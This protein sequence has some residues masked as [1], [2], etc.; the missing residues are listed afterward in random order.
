[1]RND[2]AIVKKGKPILLI[3]IAV[4]VLMGVLLVSC[5]KKP[6]QESTDA[7]AS[8]DLPKEA[9]ATDEQ[10]LRELL[11]AEGEMTICVAEDMEVDQQFIVKGT[12]TLTGDAVI[13]M[14][15]SAEWYQSLLVVSEGATL[16]MDGPVLDGNYIAD[17]IH[18]EE[19][20]NLVYLSGKI[21]RTDV[22][23]IQAMGNVSIQD[24]NIDK[25]EYIGIY[26]K[27]GSKVTIEGGS[28]TDT[29][30]HDIY[31]D[32]DATVDIIGNAR[33]KGCMGDSVINYGTLNVR[34]GTF[35]GATSYTFNNYGV[36]DIDYAGSETN[37]YVEC[38]DSRLG[39]VCTRTNAQTSIN[40]LH[41]SG[42]VRQAV[43]TVGGK[44]VITDSLFE[45]TGYHAIEIQAGEAEIADVTVN[46]A[47]DAG[48]EIYTKGVVSVK[49]FTVN[50]AAGIG[51]TCRGGK[52][53]GSNISIAN[54][55]KYGISCGSSTN[56]TT[57]GKATVSDIVIKDTGRS[58]AYAYGGAT[59]ELKNA[60]I[61]GSG[62]RGIYI[63][64]NSKCTLSGESIVT[65]C[66][67]RGVEVRGTF[68]M[69][70]GS[71]CGNY[72]SESGAG[73]Y[74]SPKGYF[75]MEGGSI[76]NNRSGL[77]GGGV[78]VTE[79]KVTVNAGNI[80]NNTAANNGGGLYAQKGAEVTL[81]T[82]SI[83][84][85]RSDMYGDGIYVV[86]EA[87]KITMSG[88]FYVGENDIKIDN[89]NIAM[90][91]TRNGLTKHTKSDPLRLTPNYSAP[92][93]TV[94]ATCK[95]VA[96]AKNVLERA[97][98]GDGS[99]IIVRDGK[100]L[101]VKYAT[102]DMD[103]TDAD[104][105]YVSNFQQLK[106]AVES[107]TSK[108][109]IILKA[110]IEFPERIR[111]PGGVTIRI[112]DDGTP[113]SLTR[114][115][116]F[117]G[118][119]FVTHYGTGLYLEG[120]QQGNLVLDGTCAETA[121][122]QPLVR[123][124]GSTVIRN[125]VLQN[126]G[127]ASADGDVRGA[128]LRQLY[129]DFEIYNSALTGGACNS[130]GAI[131]IDKGTGY[132]EGS[133][134][135]NNTSVIGGGAI[136]A[137]AN[138]ELEIVNSAF[139]QNYAGSSGGA[140][141][142]VGGA[143]VTI[144]DTSFKDN[145]AKSFGG[146]LN[147]QDEGTS[148]VITGTDA[149][150]AVFT[151][152]STET[153]GAICVHTNAQLTVSGYTFTENKATSG[154]AGA[155]AVNSG[156][157]AAFENSGFHKNEATGSGGVLATDG[158]KV[159]V[160]SCELGKEGAGNVAG[161]KG[162]AIL[163]T[164]EGEV[165]LKVA[166]D[167]TLNA[168]SNNSAIIGGA[169][170]VYNGTASVENYTLNDNSAQKSGG[171]VYVEAGANFSSN[172]C[173]FEE[174][175]A[176]KMG[177]AVYT[178]G[179]LVDTD[180]TYRANES[181]IGGALILDDD[182]KATVSGKNGQF[183]A[184]VASAPG[185]AVY[186]SRGAVAE[187][188]DYLF[189]ENVASS[190]GAVYVY[191]DGS[192]TTQ[193]TV[194]EGNIAKKTTAEGVEYGNGGA[195]Q[196]LGTYEDKS[197]SFTGN[198]GKNGGA[199]AVMS[200]GKAT[201]IATPEAAVFADNK[202]TVN[203]GAVFVNKEGLL[204]VT[205]YDFDANAAVLGGAVYITKESTATVK[206]VAMDANIANRG[207][208]IYC[209]APVTVT[210]SSFEENVA[211][212]EGGALYA[213][214]QSDVTVLNCAFA[215]N[216]GITG[217]GAIYVEA[218]AAV[219]NTGAIFVE[220]SATAEGN[221]GAVHVKGTYADA[222]SVYTGNT[223]KNGGAIAVLGGGSAT[224]IG[225]DAK[226]VFSGNSAAVKGSAVFI[227]SGRCT[228]SVEGY[229][230]T[231]NTGNGDVYVVTTGSG[232]LKNVT[233]NEG[234]A[235]SDG[236]LT[237]N[238]VTGATL[239]QGSNAAGTSIGKIY[240]AGFNAA[241]QLTVVPY[242]Y[243]GGHQVLWKA[244]GT[245]D[246]VFAE[247]CGAIQVAKDASGM[248]WSLEAD[249][250]LGGFAVARIGSETFYSLDAAVT[251]ANTNGSTGDGADMTIELLE[252]VALSARVTTSKNIAIVNASGKNVTISR[253]SNFVDDMFYVSAGKLTLGTNN[254][255]ETGKLIVDA[256]SAE[257]ISKRILDNRAGA[258]FLL[259]RNA[260]LENSNSNQWGA[261]FVN[262]GTAH[263]YGT[264]RNNVCTGAGGAVL[265]VAAADGLII[266]EGTYTGNRGTRATE[267]YGGFLRAEGSTVEIKG[268]TFADNSA[269]HRG[270]ALY[271]AGTTTAT[272]T[273]GTFTNNTSGD[274]SAIY[275][276]TDARASL[277]DLVL[278]D[279]QLQVGGSVSVNN[280]TGA[281]LVQG[282]K[283]KIYAVSITAANQLTVKPY[284][285]E[286]GHQVL[287]K[288]DGT[289]DAVLAAASAAVTVAKDGAGNLWSLNAEGKLGDIAIA[290]V[291]TKQ[292]S[293]LDAAIEYANANGGT[294]DAADMTITLLKSVALT[295]KLTV[296]KNVAIVNESGKDITISRDAAFTGAEMFQVTGKLTLGTNDTAHTGKLTVDAGTTARISKRAIANDAGAIFVLAKNAVLENAWNNQWGAALINKGTAHLYG[297]IRNNNCE[298]GAGGA[299]L[300]HG[301]SNTLIIYE[302]TYSGNVAT[303]AND[304][305][306]GFLRVEAGC[307]E[308][309]G[310]VF[311]NNSASHH[312]G[313]VYVKA[314]TSVSITGATF[315]NN[316][317]GNGNA[318]YIPAGVAASLKD[319]SLNGQQV[320][321]DGSVS[322]NNV[323]G[324]TLVQGE[325][326][327]IYAE[328]ITAANQLSVKPYKY[329]SGYV[330]LTKAQGVED[331]VFAQ[332]CAAISVSPDPAAWF[333]TAS[334][335][336]QGVAAW[337]GEQSFSNF[338]SALEYANSV[339]NATIV[340]TSDLSLTQKAVIS[341]NI[342]IT[343]NAGKEITV[344]R[345]F[346]NDDM[347]QVESGA[348]LTL[349]TADGGVLIVNGASNS[350]IAYRTVNNAG[351]FVLSAKA[352]IV[353]ANS[354]AN[355][356]ALLNSGTA[357]LSGNV[358]GNKVGNGTS[359]KGG[360]LYCEANSSTTIS[361]GTYSGNEAKQGGAIYVLGSLSANDAV[362]SENKSNG[363]EG[364]A[365]Y[366]DATKN[367][368]LTGCTFEDNYGSTAG[369][370]YVVAGG[371]V[372]CENGSFTGNTS[373][374]NGGA[375]H[376]KG[377]YIDTNSSYTNNSG[378]NGGAVAVL[379]GGSATFTGT[380]ANAIFNGNS[381]T[382]KGSAIFVNSGG[383]FAN[384]TGYTF[385]GNTTGDSA[386]YIV[387][388]GSGILKN[389]VFSGETAQKI[390]VAGTLEYWNIT[391]ASIEG[392]GTKTEK[393]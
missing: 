38:S 23:G 242:K 357:V 198:A 337:V 34:D 283:G 106:A 135:S 250:K 245:D 54:T 75:V 17:G 187:V 128:L 166:A 196:V 61:T 60:E 280:V 155:I 184:N 153:A 393:E 366:V 130:G 271:L 243:E 374:G 369:A 361:G 225:T 40:R 32:A 387:S 161:D 327:V 105:V 65:E 81:R 174:N 389:D 352:F 257:T 367:I 227:N 30:T 247:A 354:T 53:T 78:C 120:T 377:T 115:N 82:G 64:E 291:G 365:I 226:A 92:E 103:M 300:M 70:S 127:V 87:T 25:A 191:T 111:L 240:I 230:F 168:L 20:A 85:N 310:G 333:V 241:N 392:T 4:I 268:G 276:L 74:V 330:V 254:T 143:K 116:G 371:K 284:K 99:Y 35:S 114:D 52:I 376:V 347:F 281:T 181:E 341:K 356:A 383:C 205:G 298:N 202:A 312:G 279:Q 340:L 178:A 275:I 97:A 140:I 294:G 363:A 223:G 68:T 164:G 316:T 136:R 6:A 29:A 200:G 73:V 171:A 86:S 304:C 109:N 342:T 13:R 259:A 364:G 88:D 260:V 94:L 355:G 231:G 362:F 360:A 297:T 222:N 169:I 385:T 264:I 239:V 262:R 15:L 47:G 211:Q 46:E 5:G 83:K 157:V 42:T 215:R 358:T 1:M 2:K 287:W 7:T 237:I 148:V 335:T 246:T 28:F 270:G 332:A 95:S 212:K 288:A 173:I 204:D 44:T 110:D 185:A 370:I 124:A 37:G 71:I 182:G 197:S 11:L 277:K 159:S 16:N 309:R 289:D 384:A 235:V 272:I 39:V 10:T 142:A 45:K 252:D 43:V 329:E 27:K 303:R 199:V 33:L 132:I 278:S 165:E 77:R 163:V 76:Y 151:G 267:C 299:V 381:A 50:S 31:I 350:A 118:N 144:T 55:G 359:G 258:T 324:A 24:V 214:G 180:S 201:M 286:G 321:V 176:V 19:N 62:S 117:T 160:V 113:R 126:N 232:T 313:A 236:E 311:E 91:I 22:Y 308:I 210:G 63:A 175:T 285:Y 322:V 18:M 3:A 343:C 112:Q 206:D 273:G 21:W 296:G 295:K 179:V 98:A 253:A 104:T 41:V 119:L 217:G 320:Q 122:I 344:S 123:T 90:T 131:M 190:G 150:K 248:I 261:A 307:L 326:G 302:G 220:N 56:A 133:T 145:A 238:N 188:S 158:G 331:D 194:F 314:A 221:G 390:T 216:K 138:T 12:K 368:S 203:G 93:G 208:A 233:F 170:C 229:A 48:L 177:G 318:I 14:S 101:V 59:M 186:I 58:G 325:N 152:N 183:V 8:I 84:N 290:L 49:D 125:A 351:N 391:G 274:G 378:K 96:V 293:S 51:I 147:A 57:A 146:A 172:T 265:Q 26:A 167:G 282:K 269:T 9:T 213:A 89:T 373:P 388:G 79:G 317:S 345:A 129:G 72:V 121:T 80:Y 139:D 244:D 372:E 349:G 382:A 224:V 263:L 319:I 195:V 209:C 305:F 219:K 137:A 323:T 102:A 189:K 379:G 255:S 192:L 328:S 266:Y 315:T 386:V 141:V 306:G 380:N 339:E 348:T 375:V 107:T 334:G 156:A 207:A 234:T 256:A 249:G 66:D 100:N 218:D 149:A 67:Y 336:L 338:T 292:F 193:N 36:L 346:E 353:N 154:R 134:L 162:G 69:N 228:G 108:R 251:Y 301:E